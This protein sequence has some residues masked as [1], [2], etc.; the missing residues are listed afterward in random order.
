[1]MKQLSLVF[2]VL[3]S[4][5][6]GCIAAIDDQICCLCGG[7]YGVHSSKRSFILTSQNFGT[8]SCTELD[9]DMGDLEI[10]KASSRYSASDASICE[11]NRAA[12]RDCCCTDTTTCTSGERPATDPPKPTNNFPAGDHPTCHICKNQ[13][14]PRNPFTIATVAYIAGNPS[15]ADLYWM[16]RT[17]N[18]PEALCYPLQGFMENPCGCLPEGTPPSPTPPS[19]TPP[20]PLPKVPQ[21]IPK[22]AFKIGLVGRADGA[23]AE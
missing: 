11:A 9:F 19:P 7:C 20:F 18:I 3:A 13:Q 6:S 14:Y 17:N 16:G 21:T 10:D 4:L 22:D 12:H 15:C 8:V 23:A 2:L 1:M 5:L